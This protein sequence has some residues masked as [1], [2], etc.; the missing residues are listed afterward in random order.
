MQKEYQQKIDNNTSKWPTYQCNEN[1][2]KVLDLL[3]EYIQSFGINTDYEYEFI[4]STRQ[5]REMRK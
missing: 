5:N 1:H 3:A 2:L 4:V